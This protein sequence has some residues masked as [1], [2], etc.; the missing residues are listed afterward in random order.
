MTSRAVIEVIENGLR[1]MI[2]CILE[3]KKVG[4][5]VWTLERLIACSVSFWLNIQFSALL[6]SALLFFFGLEHVQNI[7]MFLQLALN[8]ERLFTKPCLLNTLFSKH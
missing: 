8:S 4:E 1:M 2:N 6:V 3:H 5:R 7:A